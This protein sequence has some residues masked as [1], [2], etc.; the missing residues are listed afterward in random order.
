MIKKSW[1]NFDI[2]TEGSAFWVLIFLGAYLAFGII[3][4]YADVALFFAV[5]VT[6]TVYAIKNPKILNHFQRKKDADS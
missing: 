1:H 5:G 3:K 4:T 6:I 2:K